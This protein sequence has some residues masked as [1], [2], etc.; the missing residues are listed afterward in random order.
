MKKHK[1]KILSL[2]V[3][4]AFLV[5]IV[6]NSWAQSYNVSAGGSFSGSSVPAAPA[7][8]D[9]INLQGATATGD[10][11]VTLP[12]T[13]TTGVLN[14]ISA[15]AAGSI[16]TIS[17]IT[18]PLFANSAANTNLTV[19]LTGGNLTFT[20]SNVS[21]NGGVFYSAGSDLTINLS[22]GSVL[23]FMNNTSNINLS[24]YKAGAAI[25]GA[26]NVTV[27]GSINLSNNTVTFANAVQGGGGAVYA[28]NNATLGVTGGSS[29]ISG[30][31]TNGSGGGAGIY[32]YNGNVTL[33]GDWTVNGNNGMQYKGAITSQFGSVVVNGNLSADGNT[34]GS[35]AVISASKSVTAGVVGGS[36]LLTNNVAGG[37]AGAISGGQDVTLLGNW[38]IEHN[39]AGRGVGAVNSG[40]SITIGDVGGVST[41][42]Y[43]VAQAYGGYGGALAAGVNVTLNG[44]WTVS[45]NKGYIA[46][47]AIV[48]I[49]GDV[50]V[51]G[52]LSADNNTVDG[53][54]GL[55]YARNNI[56]ITGDAILTG[57]TATDEGGALFARDGTVNL[58]GAGATI[59]L[60]DN[61]ADYCGGAIFSNT[62]AVTIGGEGATILLSGNT[63]TTGN[64]GAIY[65][66][67]YITLNG[68]VTATENAAGGGGGAIEGEGNV[69][70]NGTVTLSNNTAV[71]FG[72]AVG[73]TGTGGNI[74]FN[75]DVTAVGNTAGDLGGAI[76]SVNGDVAIG[77]EGATA[78][79]SDNTSAYSSG[80]AIYALTNVNITGDS[81]LT[82]NRAFAYG[83][84][85]CAYQGSVSIG[86]A[87]AT[88]TISNN[89]V[90]Y[91]GGAIFAGTGVTITGNAALENNTAAYGGAIFAYDNVSIGEAGATS[92]LT[93]NSASNGYGGAIFT[94]KDVTISGN[95]A[96]T[97]NSAVYSGGTVYGGAICAYGSVVMGGNGTTTELSN[98]TA[99]NGYGGAI[100]AVT[101]VTVSGNSIITNNTAIFGGAIMT[102]GTTSNVTIGAAGTTTT[103]SN[104][105]ATAGSGGGI[106]SAGTVTVIGAL[107]AENNTSA[108]NGGAIMVEK[109]LALNAT[110]GNFTFS[111]NTDSAGA[112][113]IYLYNTGGAAA[114]TLNAAGG[115]IIFYDPIANNAA[116]GLVTINK[117]GAGMVSFDG[118]KLGAG[119]TSLIYG[120]TTVSAGTFE[121]SNNAAY[122]ALGA[123]AGQSGASS[124][125]ALAGTTVQGGTYGTLCADNVVLDG[126]TLDIAGRQAFAASGHYNTFVIDPSTLSMN[127]TNVIFN[128]YLGDDS[129][130]S[131]LLI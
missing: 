93:G 32:A 118:D 72:G 11:A 1:S 29:V 70:I 74:I 23:T 25:S 101:G 127:G 128:T 98:N 34:A 39:S 26:G 16:V 28:E 45:Y 12:V 9:T 104:N 7:D 44:D 56:N 111:G 117:T 60:A 36:S 21:G 53:N 92:A 20:G 37:S 86:G 69:T 66:N 30:N 119:N 64:G 51:N 75:G 131:D 110:N 90:D 24:P 47:G 2:A 68:D 19:N 22:G 80:G 103:L 94:Y 114:A 58:G 85:I 41:L 8:G 54:G 105:T 42:S 112:N 67:N 17:G 13:G 130:P 35:A 96:V 95:S 120:N 31:T 71:T 18:T 73:T 49:T 121:I 3:S 97:G 123:D 113:A 40:A 100:F 89:T 50:A 107:T 99:T 126:A 124:F 88:S 122:G 38:T 10:V 33:N 62:G 79:L 76:A 27:A 6:A 48:A 78:I 102:L 129:S 77:G 55:I 46:G 61:T 87:G 63:A 84:A 83:G 14:I 52:S 115:D 81:A 57:N 109:D 106:Y 43:N 82:G 125:T 65:A 4:C 15:P 59:T 91:Y 108:G 5:T 116:N